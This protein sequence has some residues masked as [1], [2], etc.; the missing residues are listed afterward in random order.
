MGKNN[1]EVER[2][3]LHRHGAHSLV[4]KVD[5]DQENHMKKCEVE[6]ESAWRETVSNSGLTWSE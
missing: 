2:T 4:E 3:S 6:T 1:G 5:V